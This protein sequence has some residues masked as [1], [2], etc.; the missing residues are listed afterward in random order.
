MEEKRVDYRKVLSAIYEKRKIYYYVLPIAFLLS[1]LYI[2]CIPR[3]YTS[4]IEVAP[5]TDTSK[6]GAGALG[7]LASTFGLDLSS[8]ESNDAITPLLY[9]DLMEDNGFVSEMFKIKVTTAD[10]KVSTDYYD[11][12]MH[13][14]EYP[15]W[16]VLYVKI[17]QLFLSPKG[18]GDGKPDPYRPSEDDF[19][20]MKYIR[21]SIELKVDKKTGAI[22]ISTVDQDPLVAKTLAD[23]VESRLER[24]IKEYR[25]N[26]ARKDMEYYKNLA[27]QAKHDYE[28]AR[29][30]YAS[31][32]DNN[33]DALM[34]S[35]RSKQDDLEN[36][37]QLKFN[38]YSTLN[39]QLQAAMAKVQER[40]PA[41][42][43]IRGASVP[44]KPDGP[45]RMIFVLFAVVLAFMGTT[46]YVLREIILPKSQE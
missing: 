7:S 1:S 39:N 24:F 36:E 11:Y 15:W 25:T 37:M 23:S 32:S 34:V 29:Q 5:E 8:M 30:L 21:A 17:K 35:V 20:L 18:G 28:R 13:H 22:T 42:M 14:Q 9:P 31:F 3:F 41:F 16:T 38:A 46:C 2:V 33:M 44:I 6:S 19:A 43:I 26:K 45:K 4:E 10:G 27:A 12:L 40:T